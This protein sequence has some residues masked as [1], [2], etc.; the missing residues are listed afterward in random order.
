MG[1]FPVLS[2]D[3][4]WPWSSTHGRL[5]LALAA[6]LLIGLTVWTYRGVKAATPHRVAILLA[7]RLGALGLALVL[8]LRPAYAWRDDLR[9]P[10]TLLLVVD[11]S[12]SMTVRDELDNQSRWEY[13]RRLLLEAEPQ[14]QRLRE[15]YNVTI[16]TYRF[17]AD[18]AAYDPLR[19]ADGKRTD[20]GQMLTSLLERHS[21]DRALRGLLV[22]S[23]GA[24]NGTRFP[25]LELASKFR[26]LSCPIHTFGFGQRSTAQPRDVALVSITPDPSPVAVKGKLSVRAI[27]D[28]PGFENAV[29]RAQLL[30]D[31]QE[32]LASDVRLTKTTGNEV[33]LTCDA[34][35]SPGE[36]KVTLKLTALPGEVIRSNNEISTFLTVTKEGV[37]VL[38]VEGKYRAWEPKYLRMALA[39]D[40]RIRLFEAVRLTDAPPPVNEADLYQLERQHYDVVILGDITARRLSAGNPDVLAQLNNLVRERGVG[41]L[42]IGG[43][44][45][46]GNSDWSGTDIAKLLPVELDVTGQVEEPVQL[47]PTSQGLQHFVL[48]LA[49]READNQTI[50][51]QLPKLN[52]M[53]RLG[54]VKPGATVLAV[55]DSGQPLLVGHRYGEGRVLALGADTTW[56]WCRTPESLRLH[57]RFWKQ[58]VLWLAKQDEVEGSVWVKPDVR[59]IAAGGKVGFSVGLRGKGGIDI[60]NG[61]FEVAVRGPGGS[62]MPVPTSRDRDAERGMFWKT[63][64]PGEYRLTVR[65]RGQDSDGTEITGEATARF[66]VYLDEME[67]AR[68]GADPEFLTRLANAGGGT[69]QRAMELPGFLEE[70]AARPLPQGRLKAKLWPD[71]RR[72]PTSPTI[73]DQLTALSSSG[74]LTCL[75]LFIAL[76]C[77]EWFLRRMWGLV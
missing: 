42:V 19:E 66:L 50:W 77:G 29:V 74:I 59:R 34:P 69:Y 8:M 51:G 38:Y 47:V 25:A 58:L 40:P 22:L 9:V 13:L 11:A 27:V 49:D 75:M 62:N 5:A 56:R 73:R 53:T 36:I 12:E 1:T 17:A 20:F 65:G 64:V 14:L 72:S 26:A 15:E 55:T 4:T 18:L 44:E 76:L 61:R 10:S 23:D 2:F 6:L 57:A 41:L 43:Y 70:L 16:A 54:T 31:D 48:R 63:D 7:L 32:I 39:E 33:R 71:W 30:F 52:G 24:D 68:Q 3:P 45:S 35:A 60:Q 37:S 46:F 21:H 28:A 67:L